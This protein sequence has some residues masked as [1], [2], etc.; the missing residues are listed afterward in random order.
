MHWFSPV[1][2]CL[3]SLILFVLFYSYSYS[4]DDYFLKEDRKGVDLDEWMGREE[5]TESSWGKGN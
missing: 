1:L 4:L 2:S 3:F 5:E